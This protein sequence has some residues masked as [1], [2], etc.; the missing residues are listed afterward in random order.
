MLL[1]ITACNS[2]TI[3]E[4]PSNEEEQT[5]IGFNAKVQ[6]SR[7]IATLKDVQD[8][9]FKVWGGYDKNN[10]FQGDIV[11]YSKSE[12][13]WGYTDVKYWVL[14]KTYNFYALY[15]STIGTSNDLGS[16][17]IEN[18]NVK[19]NSVA[20]ENDRT[21]PIHA[22]ALNMDSNESATVN[23]TFTHMLAQVE[24]YGKMEAG[25]GTVTVDEVSIYGIPNIAT[26]T[27]IDSQWT[28]IEKS[29]SVNPFCIDESSFTL[30]TT[31]RNVLGNALWVVPVLTNESVICVTYT[32]NG[33]TK[34]KEIY[35]LAYTDGGWK[36][37]Q[38]YRYTFSVIDDGTIFFDT[39]KVV[40]W[41]KTNGSIIII[42]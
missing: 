9:G 31:A 1:V 11:S 3:E 28:P 26:Y 23:L 38:K 4:L 41:D 27:D 12:G 19:A 18:F 15:P 42:D 32:Q 37:G 29:T 36:E 21:D 33:T 10:V 7:A 22:S 13:E 6:N 34:T 14:D 2:S 17:K 25:A 30:T 8:N 40:P 24:V 35:P 20:A 39:P 16:F 5:A